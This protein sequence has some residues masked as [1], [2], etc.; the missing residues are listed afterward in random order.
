M[1]GLHPEGPA[2]APVTERAAPAPAT[3]LLLTGLTLAAYLLRSYFAG[4]VLPPPPRMQGETTQAWRYSLLVSEGRPIPDVDSLVMYPDGMA[5][6]E[7]SIFEE[8]VAG[9]AQR[10]A[11]GDFGRFMRFFCL[12]FP[13]LSISGLF[14]WMRSAGL[15]YRSSML[16]ALMYGAFLPAMLRARGES[17]YRETVALP[18]IVFACA[19][20]EM[21][22]GTR[23]AHRSAFLSSISGLLL[24]LALACWKVTAFVSAILLFYL[25][26]RRASGK[27]GRAA[28]AGPA[29]AQIAA[30]LLLTH[31]K[32]DS[33]VTS[34]ATAVAAI[35]LLSTIVNGRLMAVAGLA[36][37]TI[38]AVLGG[39][40]GTGHVTAVLIAKA[41]F[42]FMHPADPTLLSPDARLFW[43]SGYSTPSPGEL[44]L[45]F[46]IPLAAAAFGAAKLWRRSDCLIKWFLP[47]SLAGYLVFDRLHVFLALAILPAMVEIVRGMKWRAVAL[48]ML[49]GL[50]SLLVVPLAGLLEGAGL[51]AGS[52]PSLLS[53]QE[54]GGLLS[55]LR[56]STGSREPVMSYWHISGM[57]SAYAER[58]VVISTFFE[59]S[60]NRQT[61]EEFAVRLFQPEDSLAS[62][63]LARRCSLLVYQ[64][65]FVLDRSCSGALYLAGLTSVPGNSAAGLMQYRPDQL[66]RFGLVFQGPSL[67]VYRLGAEPGSFATQVLFQERYRG[68]FG[69]YESALQVVA[70]PFGTALQLASAGRENAA[71]D[72]LSAAL[73]LVC[74]SSGTVDDATGILQELLRL[75]LASRYS[76][77]NLS[78]DFEVYLSRFGPD[79][80][81]RA[82]LGQLY[83]EAGM[84]AQALDQ[85]LLALR[86][87]PGLQRALEGAARLQ[88]GARG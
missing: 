62:F 74:G 87:A 37:A 23:R 53:E 22:L 27:A 12:A 41:R 16:S 2:R 57:I 86:D 29:V 9:F 72:L 45:L 49:I 79:P 69:D 88:E 70:D 63:M 58:P 36:A 46:G 44:L 14:L 32:A 55:W 82:D 30:S 75:H 24:F 84:L 64:A 50:Q 65:D 3:A 51:R 52:Q 61:L 31:M 76:I 42:L 20:A 4:W 19:F 26:C 71:P 38:A 80:E 85:Y 81:L 54:L 13:L 28:V 68:L 48:S 17:L 56:E 66:H 35:L 40:P 15:E 47:V 39:S 83:E 21:A 33:A 11:G 59:N 18:L 1:Q 10:I 73:V 34:P 43:V 25:L 67:R 77:E 5:T 6:G 60:R 78:A 8:Y 7:N